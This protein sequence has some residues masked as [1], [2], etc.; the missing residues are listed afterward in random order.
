[1]RVEA[2]PEFR[3]WIDALKDLAGRARIQVRI[4]RLLHGN[5]GNTESSPTVSRSS[6]S[7]VGRATVFTTRL[8]ARDYC[9]C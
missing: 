5:A 9:C 8:V 4:D 1:M 2:T 3:A 6:K 7:I